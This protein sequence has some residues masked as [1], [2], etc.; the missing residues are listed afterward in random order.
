[1]L[2]ELLRAIFGMINKGKLE[3]AEQSIGEA[4]LTMLRKDSSFFMNIPEDKLTSEL[5]EN[6]N[7]TSSHLEILAELFYAEAELKSAGTNPNS[8]LSYYRKSLLLFEF[9]DLNY[10]TYSPERMDKINLIKEKI[11]SLS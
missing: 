7:Y 3:E 9:V 5:I 2:G 1:M 4:Y 8:A 10:R 11:S 6:H